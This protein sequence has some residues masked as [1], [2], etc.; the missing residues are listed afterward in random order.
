MRTTHIQ[1]TAMRHAFNNIKVVQPRTKAEK[2][3]GM[4]MKVRLPHWEGMAKTAAIISDALHGKSGISNELD[5]NAKLSMKTATA[6]DA[7]N[8][9]PVS[10]K[11]VDG[12]MVTSS[13]FRQRAWNTGTFNKM[14]A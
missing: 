4:P 14:C 2:F 6:L 13:L 10:K 5:W 7:P 11:M 12:Q 1:P 9:N 8:F 3:F